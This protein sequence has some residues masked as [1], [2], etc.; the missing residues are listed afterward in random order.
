[1]PLSLL[2]KRL[3]QISNSRYQNLSLNR[4]VLAFTQSSKFPTKETPLAET[5]VRI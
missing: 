4:D 1:M 5:L 2:I 3:L